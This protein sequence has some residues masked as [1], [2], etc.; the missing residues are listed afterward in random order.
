MKKRKMSN[1]DKLR[2]NFGKITR[3]AR[4]IPGEAAMG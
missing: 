3:S 2:C 4:F 1:E